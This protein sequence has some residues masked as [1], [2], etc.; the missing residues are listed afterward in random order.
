MSVESRIRRFGVSFM[1]ILLGQ[2]TVMRAH[3]RSATRLLLHIFER[4]GR[5]PKKIETADTSYVR[6]PFRLSKTR[7]THHLA[8]QP[9]ALFPPF[10]TPERK[11]RS[12][13]FTGSSSQKT[14]NQSCR[15]VGWPVWS[16]SCVCRRVAVRPAQPIA[17]T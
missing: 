2:G 14:T 17:A 6:S 11:V 16:R 4:R 1:E 13:R 7:S 3:T 5:L 9:S 12:G 8:Q 15:S 10:Y